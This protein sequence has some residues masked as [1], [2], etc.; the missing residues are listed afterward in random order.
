[1]LGGLWNDG[2]DAC[3]EEAEVSN[4]WKCAGRFGT[5]RWLIGSC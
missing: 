1:M 5:R 4:R 3:V 2:T